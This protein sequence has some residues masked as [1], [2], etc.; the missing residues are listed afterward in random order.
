MSRQPTARR[1]VRLVLAACAALVL[2]S[3]AFLVEDAGSEPSG[4]DIHVE[5]RPIDQFW[6]GRSQRQFG[7]LEFVGGLEMTADSRAFGSLSALRF[8]TPGRDFVGVADTGYFFFGTLEHDASGRPTGIRDFRMEP[9]VD[10]DGTRFRRKWDADAEGLALKGDLATVSFER[11]HRIAEYDLGHTPVGP[12]LR[13]LDFLV[14]AEE[15]RQNRGFETV[16]YAPAGGRLAGALVI[17]SERSL[18]TDGNMLAAILEGPRKG[19]FTVKRR[20]DFDV[21]DGVFLPGGDLLLLERNFS[22]ARGVKMRLRR[23]EAR[24]LDKGQVADGP[25]LL[26]ADMSYQID[27][28]EGLDV[29]RRSDGM[30]MVSM[31]SDDNQSL[32]QRNIYL[33]FILHDD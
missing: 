28:M 33:E 4:G 2:A 27:N 29:W 17:V 20:D 13:T 10:S 30:L 3:L 26:D 18:D 8:R 9:M 14:P 1:P 7:S 31:V 19:I 21:S 5:V 16:A 12:Q 22:M 32:L 6:I 24:T 15:L 25:V 23:I 11:N